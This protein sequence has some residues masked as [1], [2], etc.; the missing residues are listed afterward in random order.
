[1]SIIYKVSSQCSLS[2]GS[3]FYSIGLVFWDNV[4]P[5][6]NIHSTLITKFYTKFSQLLGPIH[7]SINL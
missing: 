6:G 3:R 2:W 1:M 7:L 4:F 5:C